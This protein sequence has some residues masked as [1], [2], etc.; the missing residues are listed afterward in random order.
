MLF[1]DKICRFAQEYIVY[2]YAVRAFYCKPIIRQIQ[3]T[4]LKSNAQEIKT[5]A[6]RYNRQRQVVWSWISM[7]IK[8]QI[9]TDKHNLHV[10]L[11]KKGHK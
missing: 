2:I 8:K 3:K 6:N 11:C 4:K 5:Q 10:M 1:P 7:N 9:I